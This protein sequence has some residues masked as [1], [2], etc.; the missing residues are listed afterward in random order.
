MRRCCV[1]EL[2]LSAFEYLFP[3]TYRYRST[4]SAWQAVSYG[5]NSINIFAEVGGVY[6]N[7]GLWAA[8][9]V[10]TWLVVRHFGNDALAIGT[11][12]DDVAVV[13]KSSDSEAAS[14]NHATGTVE[15]AKV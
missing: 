11:S 6:I 13:D 7:F 2:A 9:L 3:Y 10:P 8:A 12:G 15:H 4:E 1:G 5:L 14:A